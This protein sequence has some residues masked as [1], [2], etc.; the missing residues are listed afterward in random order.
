MSIKNKNLLDRFVDSYS[1]Y[2]SM[3]MIGSLDFLN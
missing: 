1:K 2:N 3:D